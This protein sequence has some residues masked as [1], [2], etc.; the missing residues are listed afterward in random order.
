[1]LSK[2]SPSEFSAFSFSNSIATPINSIR[3]SNLISVSF[4]PS[5]FSMSSYPESFKVF[6]ISSDTFILSFSLIRSFIISLNSIIFPA[7]LK[8]IKLLLSCINSKIDIPLSEDNA[9]NLSKAVFPIPLLGSFIIL[10]NA[11]LSLVF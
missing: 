5:E 6:F 2:K 1:M 7:L 11:I 3:L 9:S 4:V 10:F 8:L